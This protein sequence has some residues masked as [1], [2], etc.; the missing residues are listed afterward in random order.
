MKKTYIVPT[1]EVV[2]IEHQTQLLAGSIAE[3]PEVLDNT[4]AATTDDF[5]QLSPEF[6]FDDSE[7]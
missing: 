3:L 4:D 5:V 1:I 6:T 7:Y 2:M